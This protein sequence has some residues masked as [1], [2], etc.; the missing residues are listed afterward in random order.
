M[1]FFVVIFVLFGLGGIL[2][3][4]TFE[5]DP[6][7]KRFDENFSGDISPVADIDPSGTNNFSFIVLSDTHMGSPGGK[8]LESMLERIQGSGDG[9]V[10]SC[11]DNTDNGDDGQ[12]LAFQAAFGKF[13]LQYRAAIGNHDIFFDGWKK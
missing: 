11:G 4:T 2:A 3:C 9:F 7:V 13:N 5:S 12:Y 8:V 6:V 1:R 10:I